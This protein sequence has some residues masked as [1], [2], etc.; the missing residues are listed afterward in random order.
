M[1]FFIASK[2]WRSYGADDAK[3]DNRPVHL[4][5]LPHNNREDGRK[6]IAL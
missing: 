1:E 4:T 6:N 2:I 5:S 3:D